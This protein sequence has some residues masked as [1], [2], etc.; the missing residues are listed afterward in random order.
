MNLSNEQLVEITTY[1]F[2]PHSLSDTAKYFNLNIATL[3]HFLLKNG[4][5]LHNKSV[6]DNINREK[7]LAYYAKKPKDNVDKYINVINKILGYF[8]TKDELDN[9]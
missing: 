2:K 8:E 7:K 5:K 6:F 9:Y 4:I 1:Y 3:K